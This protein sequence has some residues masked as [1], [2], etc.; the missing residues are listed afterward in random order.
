M[1]SCTK[2]WYSCYQGGNMWAAW[3]CYLG[4]ARDILGLRLP[5][6]E[7]YKAWEDCALHGA[8]RVMHED[9]CIVSDFP[10]KIC[11]DDQHRPHCDDGPSHLW[12]DGWALWFI[13]GVRVNK[14][15][16]E[17][18]AT[19]TVRQIEQETNQEIRRIMIERFG[20]ERFIK[21]SGAAIIHQDR[22]PQNGDLRRLYRK[23]VNGDEP[24]VMVAVKNSTPEPDGSIKDYFIRVP[25][26]METTQQALAWTFGMKAS[27]YIPQVQT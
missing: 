16:V 22:D 2:R 9:F 7:K 24:I 18:P 1:L 15:I 12:R 20:Q 11:K 13:H 27:E 25:P 8:F 4:A 10:A 26:D 21:E 23:E 6:H 19:L 3:A 17:A 5:V 14:Q